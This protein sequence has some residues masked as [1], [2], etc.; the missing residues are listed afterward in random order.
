[1]NNK[2][3]FAG[4]GAPEN[5]HPYLR[6]GSRLIPATNQRKVEASELGLARN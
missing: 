1:L 4:P 2:I 3:S 6:G 5:D